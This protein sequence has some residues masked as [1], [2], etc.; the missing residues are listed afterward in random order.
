MQLKDEG[1]DMSLQVDQ[2]TQWFNT[3]WA[4]NGDAISK[5]YASTAALKGD[6]TRTRK[7][8][9][10]GALTDM[11]L[12]ISRFYSGCVKSWHFSSLA[13]TC[14]IVNDYFSQA[15]IDFLLGN[16]TSVVFQDFEANLMSVDPA[17]SMQK[18]RQ[19]AIETCQ[20][21]VVADQH[22]EF[23]AGWALLTPHAANTI[24]SMPF[25]ESVL[26]LTDA[27]LYCCK[28]DW[29][30]EKVSSFERVE[31][32][33][34]TKICYG[35]YIISTLSPSQA[36]ERTNVGF[37]VT[38]KAGSDDITRVNTRSMSSLQSRNETDSKDPAHGYPTSGLTSFLNK[39]ASMTDTPPRVL[40]MKALPSKS[41][42]LDTTEGH[43]SEIELV[44]TICSEIERMI[45]H[46][47]VVESGTERRG[48]VESGD[49]ISLADAKRSTGILEQLGH[50][51]KKLVW[52]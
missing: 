23:I 15:A 41:A 11:G 1:I 32:Q 8:D 48:I 12:S 46:G 3:L 13:Y 36:D 52:A 4:D 24:K 31:L 2:T 50:S 16:V 34:I 45:L 47:Q 14:R 18:M 49:I 26:L 17:V 19:Q 51:I 43:L 33:H 6:F 29:N 35:A 42:V 38:Y 10:K 9:Y 21:L 7:R 44:Q 28:F 22:E 5:Q 39:P 20:K 37:V 30:I 27:A 25:E 40:A